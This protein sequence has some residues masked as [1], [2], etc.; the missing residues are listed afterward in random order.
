MDKLDIPYPQVQIPWL[1]VIAFAA[2]A[3]PNF[4]KQCDTGFF[5]LKCKAIPDMP[6][7]A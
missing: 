2:L 7:N 4:G 3:S 5:P 1:S 6:Y